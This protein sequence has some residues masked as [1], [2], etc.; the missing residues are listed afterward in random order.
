MTCTQLARRRSAAQCQW[1]GGGHD[2]LAGEFAIRRCPCRGVELALPELGGEV[3]VAIFV[4][5]YQLGRRAVVYSERSRA[6]LATSERVLGGDNA[7]EGPLV[8]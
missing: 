1:A 4:C 6:G 3:V 2:A 7:G 5:V 8:G